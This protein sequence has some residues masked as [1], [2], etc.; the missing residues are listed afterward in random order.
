[1]SGIT[2]AAS[3][4]AQ[5]GPTSFV[6]TDAAGHLATANLS[7]PDIAALQS[8]VRSLR[9]Q[10]TSNQRE[11]RSGAALALAATGLQYDPR[12]GKAVDCDGG[13][14]LQGAVRH[15]GRFRLCGLG[16]LARQRGFHIRAAG[17]RFRGDR[18]RLAHAQLKRRRA[19]SRM[20]SVRPSSACD[21]TSDGVLPKTRR[22]M[23]WKFD[24]D[25]KP[26]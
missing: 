18:R 20:A 12:P 9:S 17:Q 4:A 16:S 22:N 2:S 24:T 8:Q 15:C 25:P 21:L 3:L 26:Q 19:H 23:R 13:F 11:A 1:M 7:V 14:E 6:T 10:V 5:S